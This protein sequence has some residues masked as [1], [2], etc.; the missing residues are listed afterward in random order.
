MGIDGASTDETDDESGQFVVRVRDWRSTMEPLLNMI[1]NQ[2]FDLRFFSNRGSVP[3]V[4]VRTGTVHS[5]RDAVKMLPRCF[6]SPIWLTSLK[7]TFQLSQLGVRPTPAHWPTITNLT[8][9][10][11]RLSELRD[12]EEMSSDDPEL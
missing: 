7:G 10:G 11:V 2:R 4:R 3:R 6:Y 9:G 1:D 8:D 5:T 12:D